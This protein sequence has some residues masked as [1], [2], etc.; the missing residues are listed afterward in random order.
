MSATVQKKPRPT[1]SAMIASIAGEG[2]R[3]R[4]APFGHA[5]VAEAEKRP[6][7]V[8][9]TADLSKYTD[10]HLF[11]EAYPERYFQ[12]GMAEQLLMG[13]AGG[14]AKE[15]FMP[16]ATTYAV[17]ATR[18]AYDFIHQVI[19]EE[20]LNVKICAA[21]PGL[22]TGYGPSHQATE[23]IAMMRGIPGLT[24][25]DPCDAL[26]T[27]Q[28]VAAVAAHEGPVYMRLLRGRVPLVLDEYD[29]RFELGKAKLLRDGRDV[30]VISSGIMTMRALEVA[31][32]LADGSAD[33]AVLHVPTVK[34]LDEDTILAQCRRPGRLVI[35][36][37]N[38]SRI[39]G[40]GEAVAALLMRERVQP[41]F[42]QVAL[43][44]QFLAAGALPTLHDRYGISASAFADSIRTWLG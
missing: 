15:G 13:A 39:G 12:M 38:H 11:A 10:L 26:D 14:M 28:A 9:M 5:L 42:R 30:L 20:H 8:G 6:E 16:F 21:L 29:Y 43:P 24:I 32:A 37:E 27:E 31:G 44:D 33:V 1:T 4:P 18:R 19:A 2:Q 17:F 7:I 3:T 34:P 41:V 22:T 36:A 23:D 40:L 35:V 25:V